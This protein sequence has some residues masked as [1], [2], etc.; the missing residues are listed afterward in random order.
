MRTSVGSALLLA[1]VLLGVSFASAQTQDSALTTPETAKSSDF[2]RDFSSSRPVS[3]ELL[4][5][6][7]AGPL[8]TPE[9]LV[10]PTPIIAKPIVASK[11]GELDKKWESRNTKI[12]YSLVVT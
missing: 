1:L 3:L 8:A 4:A 5:S 2:I 12:W 9:P 6:A 10:P 11:N 7:S